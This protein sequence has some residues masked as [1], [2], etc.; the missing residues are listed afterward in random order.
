[1]G[2]FLCFGIHNNRV[3]D[4]ISDEDG[5]LWGVRI[6]CSRCRKSELVLIDS[7]LPSVPL[8]K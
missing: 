6:T 4:F 1:M 2:K 5:L 3:T 8:D 7:G